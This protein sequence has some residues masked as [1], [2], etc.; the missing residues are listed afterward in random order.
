MKQFLISIG[1]NT[2]ATKNIQKA[3]ELLQST[4]STIQFTHSIQSK[5]YGKSYKDDFLN[6]LGYFSSHQ[7]RSN[8][9]KKLKNIESEMGRLPEDKIIGRV[10]IDIDLLQIDNKVLKPKDFT[11]SYVT[12]LLDFTHMK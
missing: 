11:R 7:E 5:P 10:I 4:F 9:E 12:E 1:S 8:I 3:K 2:D 6:V